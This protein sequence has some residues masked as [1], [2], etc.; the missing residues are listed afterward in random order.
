MCKKIFDDLKKSTRLSSIN[1]QINNVGKAVK[2]EIKRMSH[3]YS[4]LY[5]PIIFLGSLHKV[6]VQAVLQHLL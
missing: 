2:N 6:H 5:W 3:T 1:D 4:R